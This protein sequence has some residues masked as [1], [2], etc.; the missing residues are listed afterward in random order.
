MSSQLALRQQLEEKEAQLEVTVHKISVINQKNFKL[1]QKFTVEAGKI[2]KRLSKLQASRPRGNPANQWP[3]RP[4]T[5]NLRA[6]YQSKENKERQ[7]WQKKDLL[8]QVFDHNRAILVSQRSV[9]TNSEHDIQS[10]IRLLRIQ[11]N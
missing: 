7:L 6:F 4:I 2:Q 5:D 10:Q 8:R 11:I 1:T 3:H 9:L